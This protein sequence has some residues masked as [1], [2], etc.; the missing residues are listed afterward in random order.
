[1]QKHI[2]FR[3]TKSIVP[4][5]VILKVRQLINNKRENSP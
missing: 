2:P 4:C 3:K 1:M 5:H